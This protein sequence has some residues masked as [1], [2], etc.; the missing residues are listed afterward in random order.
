MLGVANSPSLAAAQG[1][2]TP[3]PTQAIERNPDWDSTPDPIS[4][5]AFIHT[6]K[7]NQL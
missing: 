6:A 4:H 7:L 2:L 5:T 3:K 1:C